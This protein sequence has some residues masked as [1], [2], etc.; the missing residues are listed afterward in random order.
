MNDAQLRLLTLL[1]LWEL[2]HEEISIRRERFSEA[3]AGHNTTGLLKPLTILEVIRFCYAPPNGF[4]LH[5]FYENKRSIKF[6]VSE[7]SLGPPYTQVVDVVSQL[8]YRKVRRVDSGLYVGFYRFNGPPT[9][10]TLQK[11]GYMLGIR[12]LQRFRELGI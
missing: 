10:D 7:V 12:M 2:L 5:M 4:M 6:T 1:Q 9:P 11:A 8:S 3:V